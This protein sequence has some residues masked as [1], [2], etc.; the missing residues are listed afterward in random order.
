MGFVGPGVG[1]GDGFVGFNLR[2]FGLMLQPQDWSQGGKY[3]GAEAVE[4]F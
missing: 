3:L 4:E 1:E 2:V